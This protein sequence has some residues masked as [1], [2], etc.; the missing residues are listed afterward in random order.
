VFTFHSRQGGAANGVLPDHLHCLWTLPRDDTDF[1]GRWLR[2]NSMLDHVT[3]G[4][5]DLERSKAFYDK[6]LK[7]IGI[8]RLYSEGAEFSGYGAHK[9]AFFWIGLKPSAITGVHV[10]FAV[11]DRTAVDRFYAAAVGITS[12]P[13]T[14]PGLVQPIFS[15]PPRSCDTG[16][17]GL[18]PCGAAPRI[19]Y[20][21]STKPLPLLDL[22][23]APTCP[24]EA[25]GARMP[26]VSSSAMM[27]STPLRAR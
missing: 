14:G 7:A 1:P 10:A 4:V 2:D 21:H 19:V 26:E 9:K 3:I 15:A 5:S 11:P 13:P 17:S 18:C 6:A 16:V 25:C 8:E 27:R 22:P 24:V 12:P 20:M 23:F